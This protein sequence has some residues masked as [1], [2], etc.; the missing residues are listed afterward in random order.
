[1]HFSEKMHRNSE[2]RIHPMD[3]VGELTFL[4][5]TPYSWINTLVVVVVVV[6]TFNQSGDHKTK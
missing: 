6:V 2:A 4:H 5:Q 1:M 3:P